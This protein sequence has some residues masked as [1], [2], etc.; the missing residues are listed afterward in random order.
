MRLPKSIFRDY[1]IRGIYPTEINEEVSNAIG[2][3]LGTYISERGG[4][5]IVV[6]RDNRSSSLFLAN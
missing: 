2:K 1:D 4:K 3:A 6:A 5:N